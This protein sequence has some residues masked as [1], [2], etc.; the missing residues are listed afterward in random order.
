MHYRLPRIAA[1]CTVLTALLAGCD[2]S[3][4]Q[5]EF[6]LVERWSSKWCADVTHELDQCKTSDGAN[7]LAGA[8]NA[9]GG[10]SATPPAAIDRDTATRAC[11]A[12]EPYTVSD[13][14]EL[15][16]AGAKLVV[17]GEQTYRYLART[18]PNP[19]EKDYHLVTCQYRH[20]V[21]EGPESV[22]TPD[23]P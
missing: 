22:L 13:L 10:V 1:T 7:K 11:L 4:V 6:K 2:R 14:N 3:P 16:A 12:A 9:L 17:R 20:I 8:V 5:R 23:G 18:E 15:L 21:L 19:G